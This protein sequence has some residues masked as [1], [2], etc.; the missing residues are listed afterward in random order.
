MIVTFL[1]IGLFA[2]AWLLG[3]M[4]LRAAE[5]AGSLAGRRVLLHAALALIIVLFWYPELGWAL[6]HPVEV[7]RAAWVL[8]LTAVPVGS[9]VLFLRWAHRRARQRD[10]ARGRRG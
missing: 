4:A 2:A 7:G 10:A 3:R 5:R 9:F 1:K 8:V 6:R